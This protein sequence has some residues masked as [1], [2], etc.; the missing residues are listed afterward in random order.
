MKQTI[1]KNTFETNSSSIHCLVVS[2]NAPLVDFSNLKL[3]ITPYK[4]EE[5]ND[6]MTFN[7]IEDKLRYLWTIVCLN[8][9]YHDNE[10]EAD[11]LTSALRAVFP[12]VN[13]LDMDYTPG[14]LEDYD[15]VFKNNLIY[16][17]EFLNK[18]VSS[19]SIDFTTRDYQEDN[20]EFE[21]YINTL[22]KYQ[23]GKVKDVDVVWGEG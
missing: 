19:G 8:Y 14:Y 20:W 21:A 3:F 2:K 12:K 15:Y 5:V 17:D 22:R 11:E 13:F 4:E 6:T 9:S 23:M 18:L 16:T 1:R 10:E 7:T